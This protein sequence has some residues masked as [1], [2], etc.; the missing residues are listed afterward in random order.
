MCGRSYLPPPHSFTYNWPIVRIVP[1]FNLGRCLYAFGQQINLPHAKY[2]SVL[3][4]VLIA[5][6]I[7]LLAPDWLVVL[8]LASLILVLAELSKSA[9]SNFMRN[10]ILIYLGEISYSIYMI[11]LLVAFTLFKTLSFANL[12][13]PNETAT[14]VI[15]VGIALVFPVPIFL[16]ETAEKP[17]RRLVRRQ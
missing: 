14:I 3:V 17:A 6:E 8:T 10:R 2:L 1:E 11:H 5:L 7:E 12:A 4:L 13:G 15:L 9:S 16:Y